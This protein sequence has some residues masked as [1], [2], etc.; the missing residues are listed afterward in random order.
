M[1]A[2]IATFDG[3]G[4]PSQLHGSPGTVTLASGEQ[5]PYDRYCLVGSQLAA[6]RGRS[7]ETFVEA[8]RAE[9]GEFQTIESRAEGKPSKILVVLDGK[10]IVVSVQQW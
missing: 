8:L 3:P 7:F 1:R 10:R 2:Q 5:L 4:G 9:G 6:D